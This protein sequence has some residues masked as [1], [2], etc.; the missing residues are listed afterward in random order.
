[1]ECLDPLM[2]LKDTSQPW[3]SNPMSYA[4]K[5]EIYP[6]TSSN[7][8]NTFCTCVS[9]PDLYNVSTVNSGSD[10]MVVTHFLFN[11]YL[12]SNSIKTPP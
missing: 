12:G 9:E 3:F 8:R 6:T 11:I 10:K 7:A 1:M 4:L 5:I 2:I